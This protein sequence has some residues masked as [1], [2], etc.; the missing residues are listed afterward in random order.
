MTLRPDAAA[1]FLLVCLALAPVVADALP[2]LPETPLFR[3]VGT[4]DGLPSRTVNKL[5]QDRAGYVWVGTADGLARFDGNA[6]RLYQHDAEDPASLPGNVIETLHVDARDRLWIGVEGSGL[7]ML[8][9][10]REGFTHFRAAD[11]ARFALA[12]VWA[13]TSAADGAIW[14]GGYDGGLYRYEPETGAVSVHRH[15]P[16]RA[17]SLASDVVL[18]LAFDAQQRLWVGSA[19]G[20][21]RFDGKAFVTSEPAP[22]VTP[23][24]VMSLSPQADGSLLV[25]TRT[26]LERVV[27]GRRSAVATSPDAQLQ[28]GVVALLRDRGGSLWAGTRSGISLFAG[29]EAHPVWGAGQPFDHARPASVFDVLE[30]HEGGLWFAAPGFGLLRTPPRWRNFSALRAAPAAQGGLSANRIRDAAEGSDGSLWFVADEGLLDHVDGSGRVTRYLGT[31]ATRLPVPVL[32]SVLAVDDAVWIGYQHGLS[33]FEPGTGALRHWVAAAD[34]PQAPPSGAIDLLR[35]APDGSVW[36]SANGGGLQHRDA[37]GRVLGTYLASPDTGVPAPD[38]EDLAF[39][40]DGAVWISGEVGLHRFDEGEN[41]FERVAGGPQQ[42]VFG[43]AF[44]ADGTLWAQR[45]GALEHFELRQGRLHLLHRVGAEVGF[46]ALEVGGLVIDAAGD[47]W[48]TSARGLWHYAPAQGRLRRYG[49]RDGLANQ[50][51]SSNPPLR[52]RDGS[53]IAP[54]MNGVVL[55]DPRRIEVD[56]TPPRLAIERI[57]V[58]RDGRVVA[59]DAAAPLTLRHDDRELHVQARLFSFVDPQANRYR[60]RLTGYEDAWIDAGA[61]GERVFSQLPPGEYALKV[62]GANAEGVWS[63]LPRQIPI[64]V[65]PPWW[66]T[67]WA[68]LAWIIA[69]AMLLV[70]LATLYRR[71]LKRRHADELA[72][73]QHRLALQASDA[74]TSFLATMGHEIRTPMTGVLGMTELLLRSP[75][76]PRQRG[77]AE[78]IQ[79]SGDMMLR[80]VNDALDLARI[81]AGKFELSNEHLDLHGLLRDVVDLLRALAERKSLALGLQLDARAP[82]LVSGDALR[83]KQVLLNLGNNALKFTEQGGVD[84]LLEAAQAPYSVVIA[85]RDTGPGLDAEQCARLFRRFEQADG[86]NTTRRYGGS[87]LGLAI[88][89]ELAAAMGGRIDVASALGHGCEFRLR[90]PL[91]VLHADAVPDAAAPGVPNEPSTASMSRRILLVEDDA[92]V[93]EVVR[94]LL[95]ALGHAVV[96]AGNGLAALTELDL[97]HFDLAFLDLDLPGINGIDLARL[98]RARAH[99]LPLVALTARVDPQ[100]EPMALAAGMNGFLRK[101]VSGAALAEAISKH[102]KEA[103]AEP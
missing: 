70:A 82:R 35:R 85:V 27:D 33:R 18:A 71:R 75:L 91:A 37:A 96:R 59:L 77:Y 79:R 99:T 76:E 62:E 84:V 24:M 44:A 64:H 36:L 34:D 26:G 3:V 38:T 86:A 45:L 10:A 15:D 22:G 14:F 89:Q 72:E 13:I 52:L 68:M 92:T 94:G 25:G 43:F 29:D 8:G 60:F 101:P 41:R 23:A 53:I 32:R 73:Q 78:A 5:A 47:L 97:H 6:F 88:C 67:P 103:S 57:D 49:V 11:D 87:G 83:L 30:D 50:E 54:T 9:P 17:D 80:L 58:R 20:L 56:R 19:A 69:G 98:I 90:L 31:P 51:F 21:Q 48:M 81:E 65:A 42:R 74:K 1:R 39:A 63:A 93:A 4:E 66:W 2:A 12:D 16:T 61:S 28:T 46:P 40:P 95:E 102:V 100:A 55:F 7:S